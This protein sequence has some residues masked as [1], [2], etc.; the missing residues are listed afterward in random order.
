MI[1]PEHITFPFDSTILKIENSL[2]VQES[3]L[4]NLLIIDINVI[5]TDMLV[6]YSAL[7]SVISNSHNYPHCRNPCSV[8]V[9]YCFSSLWSFSLDILEEFEVYP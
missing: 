5:N 3:F 1:R 2:S 8:L 7:L 9:I 6:T 4:D